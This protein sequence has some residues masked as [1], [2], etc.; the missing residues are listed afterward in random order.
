MTDRTLF[1]V[2]LLTKFCT[3]QTLVPDNLQVPGLPLAEYRVVTAY[4]DADN[5]ESPVAKFILE[6]V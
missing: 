6:E 1:R 3:L 5:V 4:I 2:L